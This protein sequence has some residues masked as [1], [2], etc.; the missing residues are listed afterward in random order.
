MS[1]QNMYN[2]KITIN[3]HQSNTHYHVHVYDSYGQEHHLGYYNELSRE[4]DKEIHMRAE[5]IW[6][7]ETKREISLL[8]KAIGECIR[9][10]Q[11]K[12]ITKNNRDGLD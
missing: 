8:S 2:R 6:S 9:I 5:E 3:K 1:K 4:N 11:E 10:D 7:N 12:G